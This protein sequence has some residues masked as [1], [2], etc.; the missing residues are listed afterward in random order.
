[1]F[2][3][4]TESDFWFIKIF[5]LLSENLGSEGNSEMFS[6]NLFPAVLYIPGKKNKRDRITHNID[7]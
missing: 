2:I 3:I 5:H 6:A 7:L 4:T 1:M